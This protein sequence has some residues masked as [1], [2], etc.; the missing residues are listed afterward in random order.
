MD[1]LKPVPA[2]CDP[3][4]KPSKLLMHLGLVKIT[5]MFVCPMPDRKL[6]MG[7]GSQRFLCLMSGFF[8][9]VVVVFNSSWVEC[10]HGPAF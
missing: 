3:I 4:S 6:C 9:V 2:L 1:S 5:Q 10:F 8:V 7:P